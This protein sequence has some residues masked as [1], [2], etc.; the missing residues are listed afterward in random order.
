ML[1][2]IKKLESSMPKSFDYNL[3]QNQTSSNVLNDPI[4]SDLMKLNPPKNEI[5]TEKDYVIPESINDYSSR[6]N[7][8][9]YLLLEKNDIDDNSRI[10]IENSLFELAS[11]IPK[12]SHVGFNEPA[13]IYPNET[14]SK[15]LIDNYRQLLLFSSSYFNLSLASHITKYLVELIYSL[16]YWEV[17]HLLYLVPDLDYYL[18][19]TNF[20]IFQTS[21]GPIV[22]PPENYLND[23]MLCGLQY[24]FPYPFYNY[25]YHSFDKEANKSKYKRIEIMPYIDIT[26]KNTEA[27]GRKKRKIAYENEPKKNVAIDDS[28]L[29]NESSNYSDEDSDDSDGK[30][31]EYDMDDTDSN[32][33]TKRLERN[34]SKM[35]E[36]K[37]LQHGHKRKDSN[38][39]L[40]DDKKN[41]QKSGVIHQCHLVDPSTLRTCLKIFYGK[42]ELLR[43]QEFVHA[44]KKKIYKCIY[45]SRNGSKVQ[46][47][48]RHDSLAR[49]IRRKHG[50]TG[51]ENKMAVNYAKENVE[52]IEEPSQV[53]SEQQRLGK[54][55]PHPQF[56]NPDFTVKSSYAGFSLFS[57]K[58]SH[59]NEESN[60][61]NEE[62]GADINEE[63][64]DYHKGIQDQMSSRPS[65]NPVIDVVEL[66]E[67]HRRGEESNEHFKQKFDVVDEGLRDNK[68]STLPHTNNPLNNLNELRSGQDNNQN[69]HYVRMR[70]DEHHQNKS[71]ADYERN[72]LE[73]L[74]HDQKVQEEHRQQQEQI[75]QQHHQ[76]Q[77]QFH[78][79]FYHTRQ[80]PQAP[81]QQ[82]HQAMP[83]TFQH[84]SGHQP[85]FHQPHLHPLPGPPLTQTTPG[86]GK[87]ALSPI[88]QNSQVPMGLQ[89][90]PNLLTPMLPFTMAMN[91][92]MKP[93]GLNKPEAPILRD[94][95]QK[96][97][98]DQSMGSNKSAPI[99]QGSPS[100]HPILVNTFNPTQYHVQKF[101]VPDQRQNVPSPNQQSQSPDNN[102][103]VNNNQPSGSK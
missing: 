51:K 76:Q 44:T 68:E 88:S 12:S 38:P 1:D 19:L 78:Q 66:S 97:R 74:Q 32:L 101:Q 42:N 72:K 31:S 20:E 89:N 91:P 63:D 40:S 100:Q 95:Y 52:I 24:P 59:H 103:Y 2:L 49:H 53:V 41:K 17:Y 10:S 70:Q 79:A 58:G 28:K 14:L 15:I 16:N 73:K 93:I 60:S 85:I 43:H 39:D 99:H 96:F 5:R 67:I 34:S 84:L 69:E 83:F 29:E 57:T 65:K 37:I 27:I 102:N 86:F 50:V 36:L 87:H 21:F 80:S 11:Y 13:L 77:Q 46:S 33:S 62:N 61:G 25:S 92:S 4:M 35:N 18:K 94:T 23:A 75:L 82:I 47:Y 90:S 30:L 6:L 22:K 55:L 98:M 64:T 56:L 9:L 3:D 81:I 71:N 54:P 26:L 8:M 7:E 45:C 48:P